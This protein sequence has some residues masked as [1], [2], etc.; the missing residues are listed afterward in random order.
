MRVAIV[1][2]CLYPF[3]RGGGERVYARMA[4]LLHERGVEV[5]YLTR[6]LWPAAEPEL[7]F[8]VIPIWSG[9]IYDADGTRTLSSAMGFALAAG[10]ELRRR[11][12]D[13]DLVLVAAL[14]VLNVL[15]A[16]AALLGTR[17]V[18]A[19]DWLE[20][21]SWRKWR[22][23]S[24][25]MAGTVATVLQC[26][27]ARL[28]RIHT[29]NS[30]FT[31]RAL[32]RLRPVSEPIVL[33][34][35]DLVG[36]RPEAAAGIRGGSDGEPFLL[37]VGR[38]IPDKRLDRIPAA[39]AVARR[40]VPGL[41]LRVAGSGPTTGALLA[42]AVENGV[43]NEVQVLGRVDDEQLET[44]LGQASVLVSPSAREG[45]G[46]V[47]AEAAA[48]GTPSVVV[49]GAD[50]AAAELVDDGVNGFVAVDA[51]AEALGAAIVAALNGGEELHRST[52]GWFERERIERG[53]AASID[54]LLACYDRVR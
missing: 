37:F 30:S 36:A 11:R 9:D 34:L 33:G 20:I 43:A 51:S 5:D 16:W 52:L 35:V 21:W 25:A 27:A 46:L 12:G 39:L 22:S 50:N 47:V 14:P 8:R 44:L 2:D 13:Y 28:G 32:R 54:R 17:S 38:H 26:I 23:Y 53:L 1:Y 4:E 40:S 19:T 6:R 10:R 41:T 42:A 18:L 29:V 48:H 24:G 45:F 49:A 3:V 15:A 7:P 31:A